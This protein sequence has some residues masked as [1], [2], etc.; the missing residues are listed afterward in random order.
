ML[1]RIQFAIEVVVGHGVDSDGDASRK[2]RVADRLLHVDRR[3]ANVNVV[4]FALDDVP[5]IEGSQQRIRVH[6]VKSVRLNMMRTSGNLRRP[7]Q[8]YQAA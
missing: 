4:D 8:K 2:G 5:T 3:H 6:Y 7:M 1:L